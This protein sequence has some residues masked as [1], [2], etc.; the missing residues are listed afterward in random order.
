VKPLDEDTC[1]TVKRLKDKWSSEGKRVI[2]LARKLLCKD[3]IFP[4]P[5][6]QEFET[7]MIREAGTNLTLIGLVGMIDSPRSEVPEVMGILRRA[8]IRVFMVCSTSCCTLML[9]A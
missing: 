3:S 2:L 4:H 6:S 1:I 7:Q 9:L 8:H 5:L